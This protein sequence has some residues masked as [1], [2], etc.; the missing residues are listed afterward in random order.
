MTLVRLTVCFYMSIAVLG[1]TG[2]Y[3]AASLTLALGVFLM[4]SETNKIDR[5]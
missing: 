1:A 5:Q 2:S 4:A 3:K